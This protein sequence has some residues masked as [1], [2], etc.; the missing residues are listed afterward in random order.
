MRNTR[1]DTKGG[2]DFVHERNERL[3]LQQ[4]LWRHKQCMYPAVADVCMGLK[5]SHGVHPSE[6]TE[7]I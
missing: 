6:E 3:T 1:G 5:Y 2:Q 4:D 7:T